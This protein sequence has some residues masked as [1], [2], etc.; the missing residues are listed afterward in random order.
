IGL[1]TRSTPNWRVDA[2][3]DLGTENW[4]IARRDST[5]TL[6]TTP[7]TRNPRGQCQTASLTRL[8]MAGKL[9][10]RHP[11]KPG[12]EDTGSNRA[13]H[14]EYGLAQCRRDHRCPVTFPDAFYRAFASACCSASSVPAGT[15]SGN[16]GR[17]AGL[18]RCSLQCDTPFS[19]TVAQAAVTETQRDIS[20]LRQSD[21]Y[22]LQRDRGRM[23]VRSRASPPGSS[24]NITWRPTSPCFGWSKASGTC[25]LYTSPS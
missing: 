12:V 9:V 21:P 20:N 19:C 4:P 1:Q 6:R 8:S 11:P 13:N 2:G 5:V 7:A 14:R 3:G 10:I 24:W 17:Q 25:L 15:M 16:L 22:S 18:V 23:D